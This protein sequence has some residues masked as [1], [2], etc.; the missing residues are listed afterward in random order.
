ML[1]MARV[2][3]RVE[4]RNQAVQDGSVGKLIQ[5]ARST[6]E[7]GG[8]T[9]RLLRKEAD[10]VHRVRPVGPIRHGLVRGAVL[11]ERRCGGHL[12]NERQRIAEGLATLG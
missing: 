7:A 3:L 11:H 12:N 2:G 1:V 5:L 10:S 9:L 8:D 6:L 4:S